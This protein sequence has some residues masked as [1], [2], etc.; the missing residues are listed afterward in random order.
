MF[1][2]AL[3]QCVEEYMMRHQMSFKTTWTLQINVTRYSFLT[4]LTFYVLVLSFEDEFIQRIISALF[5]GFGFALQG[6]V[7]EVILTYKIRKMFHVSNIH[8]AQ[9]QSKNKLISLQLN[10]MNLYGHIIDTNGTFATFK[11]KKTKQTYAIPYSMLQN[12]VITIDPK[13]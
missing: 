7:Q 6:T 3:I 1:F 2:D 10:N 13:S 12:S 11:D 5:V 8:N 9:V 4:L